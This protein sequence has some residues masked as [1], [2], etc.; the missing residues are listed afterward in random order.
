MKNIFKLMAIALLPITMVGCGAIDT[1][2]AG[3]RTTWDQQV[4]KQT[5]GEGFFVAITSTVEEW[6]GKEI[7]I[8]LNDMTPKAGDNLSME[9]LDI[10]IWYKADVKQF[11]PA[12]KIKYANAHR[13]VDDYV[14]PAYTLIQSQGRTSVYKGVAQLDSLDIHKK[15]D[16]LRKAITDNLQ[17]VL[18]AN[19][20]SVFAITRVII[21]QAKT[22]K[23]LEESIQINIKKEKELEAKEKEVAI[24]GQEAAANNALASSLTPNIMRMKELEAMVAACNGIDGTG[25]D[26][27]CILDFTGGRTG[28][29]PL[30][31]LPT[32]R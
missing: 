12:L 18:D 19:D 7:M 26:N 4:D 17:A 23:T 15:R 10:E 31:N 24:K 9:D 11:G 13:Y 1:N 16:I 27:I 20:P 2:N 25:S 14:F 30:I 28:I 6:V 32:R 8:P 3:V 21:K 29:T 22:D 5:V